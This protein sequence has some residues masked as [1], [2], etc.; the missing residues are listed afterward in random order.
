MFKR[1]NE[2]LFSS[3]KV[4]HDLANENDD[5]IDV[6]NHP[7][8]YADT[9]IE[10]IDYIEDKKINYHLGNVIKYISRAGKKDADKKL[11]DLKKA[12]WYLN[13]Y[14]TKFEIGEVE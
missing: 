3:A 6:I 12:Q 14:I 8:H 11:E 10:V 5:K 7:K 9:K 2:S 4:V 13:R 1:K